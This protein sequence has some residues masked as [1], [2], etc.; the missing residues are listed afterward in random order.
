[1]TL[2]AF[3]TRLAREPLIHFL[4]LGAAVFAL[5]AGRPVDPAER[6]IVV[7]Q[8][9]VSRL[10]DRWTMTYRRAPTPA[11]IDALI[12]DYVSDQVYYRE[13]LRLGLDRDDEVVIRRM[14]MKLLALAGADAEAAAPGDADLRRLLA[15]TPG[16]YAPEPVLTF[17]QLYLGVDGAAARG[18]APRLIAQLNAGRPATDALPP[19]A[20]AR[21]FSGVTPSEVAEQ[22]GDGFADVIQRLQPGEWQGPL[23]SGLGFHLVKLV[24][25]PVSRPASF[26]DIRQRLENDWRSAETRRAEERSYRQ[27]AE[28][29]DVV[30]KRP[31]P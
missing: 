25:K 8:A 7:D 19:A 18:M 21:H 30:I 24:G 5:M 6:R 15:A 12:R 29:Y 11:E 23:A 22:F 27:M 2:R 17:D 16:R 10:V 4:L 9:V 26:A 1:M 28:R 13:G 31:R 20:I 14:R 3:A